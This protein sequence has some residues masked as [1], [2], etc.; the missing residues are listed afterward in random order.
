MIP[1][2]NTDIT[3]RWEWRTFAAELGEA[4]TAIRQHP[5]TRIKQSDELYLISKI[6]GNN[7]KIRD[8]LLNIKLLLKTNEA[9][10]EQ[11]FPTL[12]AEFPLRQSDLDIFYQAAGLPTP[13]NL[14]EEYEREQFFS[15][16]VEP[17][18]E[19]QPVEVHKYRYGFIINT[20]IVEI[21]NLQIDGHAAVSAA[22]EHANP[23]R[24]LSTVRELGLNKFENI[25][26]IK[27]IRR[28][29]G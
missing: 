6:S 26:Y 19:L 13:D 22:V 11:W 5:C 25:N 28:L 9:G 4:E 14:R 12:K 10:L 27:G 2:S 24:V 20:V 23:E 7:I 17:V 1:K 3:A 16:L 8:G 29:I 15:E 18:L 21:A